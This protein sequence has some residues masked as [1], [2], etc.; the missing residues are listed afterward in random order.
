MSQGT[1]LQASQ[2]ATTCEWIGLA[3]LAVPC[4]IY[5]MDLTV[6]NL[7]VP[8]LAAELRPTATQLLWI[9]DVYGFMVAGFL[10]TMG[11]LGDRIGRRRMLMIG[12]MGFGAT[13]VLAA[14]STS[15]EM[16]I[17]ARALQGIA[18][19]TLAPSTL[20]LIRAM[21][22]DGRERT[23][24]IG[25]WVAS[26]SAGAAL[27]PV[28]GG[29]II[30]HLWWGAVFLVN[31]PLMAALLV[32]AWILLP[33]YR[34]E[35]AGRPD[36]A[37][38]GLALVSVLAAIYGIKKLAEGGAPVLAVL[39]VAVGCLMGVAFV[40][41]QKRLADPLIDVTLFRARAF[42][43]ALAVNMMGLFV[44]MAMFLFIAQYL[45]S[46]LD[47]GPLEAGLW[48]A[49][50]GI[51]FA[52]GSVLTPA[53]IVRV[54]RVKVLVGGFLVAA[55]GFAILAL[56]PASPGILT[57]FTGM[58]VLCI[59]LAPVGT[60]TTDIV[61]AAAPP[62]RAG[63][64]SAISE[65]SFEFGAA[66][67]IAV[68]GSLFAVLYRASLDLAGLPGLSPGSFPGLGADDLAAVQSGI[69]G[70]VDAAQ[71]LAPHLA[72][73]V[74]LHARQAFMDAF[75]ATSLVAALSSVVAAALAH[76]LLSEE[77]KY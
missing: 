59:G 33:E 71:G 4:L 30:E 29:V 72:E 21:F 56:A 9:V 70:A 38:A 36:F 46:V 12:A 14:F 31:A 51:V 45:Q 74:I 42:S 55:A 11:T 8:S 50:S 39:A 75:A 23:F 54:P 76:L 34:D 19:A 48:T 61:L 41:R 3:V 27:G 68:L 17:V 73:R 49:P 6:L 32:L 57:L 22:H 64:A 37:S 28:F 10:V 40:R 25:V 44:V 47:L 58:I 53:L 7:A 5:A 63:A 67:G 13:S 62:E 52:I 2:K 66:A 69:E 35:A 15:P 1:A 65:T 77:G 16:L 60:I 18:G 24:A 43:G 26:F 20:S